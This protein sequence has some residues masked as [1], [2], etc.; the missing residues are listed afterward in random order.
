MTPDFPSTQDSPLSLQGE[1]WGEG[2]LTPNTAAPGKPHS[3]ASS[4][5]REAGMTGC[6]EGT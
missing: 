5:L 2:A 1:G 4:L 6:E 3:R